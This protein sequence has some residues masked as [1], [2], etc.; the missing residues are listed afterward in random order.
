LQ[1]DVFVKNYHF[2]QPELLL[3][4]PTY[5]TIAAIEKELNIFKRKLEHAENS[6]AIDDRQDLNHY[7]NVLFQNLH[8][9]NRAFPPLI[10]E[11]DRF[12]T[13]FDTEYEQ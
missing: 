10:E 8:V 13:E 11:I 3:T 6:D 2:P 7:L 9:L 1:Q 5:L 12:D 4:M